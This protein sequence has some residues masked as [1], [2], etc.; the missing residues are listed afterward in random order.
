[1]EAPA[2]FGTATTNGPGSPMLPVGEATGPLLK[3]DA[4]CAS[5]SSNTPEQ[6]SCSDVPKKSGRDEALTA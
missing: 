1:M 3:S 5:N 4:P 2:T 6:C